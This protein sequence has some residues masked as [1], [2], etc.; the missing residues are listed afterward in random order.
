MSALLENSIFHYVANINKEKDNQHFCGFFVHDPSFK[1]IDHT[2]IFRYRCRV[3][4]ETSNCIRYQLCL[5]WMID[6]HLVND[7]VLKEEFDE[8]LIIKILARKSPPLSL[9]NNEGFLETI[10]KQVQTD[11]HIIKLRGL[12]S[13]S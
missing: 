12:L 3:W 11:K 10:N 2:H 4:S 1:D 6:R 9:F 13:D 8:K 7:E 5:D